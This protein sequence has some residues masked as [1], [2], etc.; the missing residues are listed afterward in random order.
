MAHGMLG[1]VLPIRFE[2][3]TPEVWLRGANCELSHLE[4]VLIQGLLAGT[5][6]REMDPVDQQSPVC[7]NEI[8]CTFRINN[9][10]YS[11]GYCTG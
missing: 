11:S 3:C 6:R 4:P 7:G 5:Q 8:F 2:T 10:V 9:E 1:E